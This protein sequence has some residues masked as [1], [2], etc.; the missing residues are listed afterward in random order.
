MLAQKLN[1]GRRVFDGFCFVQT[2][3]ELDRFLK[4]SIA[5]RQL[6]PAL[7]TPEKIGTNDDESMRR[8]PIGDAPQEFIH[9]KNLLQYDDPWAIPARGQSHVGIELAAV[10]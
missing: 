9:A 3:I 8:I 2:L 6:H 1:R 5:V 10:E 7:L 4:V